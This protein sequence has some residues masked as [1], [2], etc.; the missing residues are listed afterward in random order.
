MIENGVEA[1]GAE[2]D[3]TDN[4]WPVSVRRGLLGNSA[5]GRAISDFISSLNG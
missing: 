5:N 4:R 2:T 3:I 1:G